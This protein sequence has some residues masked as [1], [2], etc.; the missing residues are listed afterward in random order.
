[1][2]IFSLSKQQA[3]WLNLA[4]LLV[5]NVEVF[6]ILNSIMAFAATITFVLFFAA[7]GVF[8]LAAARMQFEDAVTHFSVAFVLGAGAYIITFVALL[9]FGA[10]S[11]AF[12]LFSLALFALGIVFFLRKQK[13]VR[14]KQNAF[15]NGGLAWVFLYCIAAVFLISDFMIVTQSGVF[16]RD[17]LHAT[18][19]GGMSNF[20]ENTIFTMPDLAYEGKNLAYHFG[21]PILMNFLNETL[22]VPLLTVGYQIIPILCL[23]FFTLLLYAFAK[24]L[25]K[26]EKIRLFTILVLLFANLLVIPALKTMTPMLNWVAFMGSYGVGLIL[27]MCLLLLLEKRENHLV[28]EAIILS[29]LAFSKSTLF[30]PIFATYLLTNGL[31][32]WKTR[33]RV[34]LW[35][36]LITI[37]GLFY[38]VFLILAGTHQHNLWML[39]PGFMGVSIAHFTG[40]FYYLLPL[41]SLVLAVFGIFGIVAFF[42]MRGVWTHSK[43]LWQ[44]KKFDDW[45]LFVWTAIAISALMTIFLIEF[46]EGNSVQFVF[47][48]IILGGMLFFN[49]FFK[50]RTNRKFFTFTLALFFVVSVIP[51]AAIYEGRF[52]VLKA[53]PDSQANIITGIKFESNKIA[54][55]ALGA[56]GVLDVIKAVRGKYFGACQESKPYYGWYFYSNDLLQSLYWLRENTQKNEVVLFGRHY[57]AN[58]NR[59]VSEW[60]PD[61]FMRSAISQRQT[62]VEN[63]QFRGEVMQADYVERTKEVVRFYRTAVDSATYSA[64]WKLMEGITPKEFSNSYAWYFA[65]YKKEFFDTRFA[66]FTQEMS[67]FFKT[68]ARWSEEEKTPKAQSFLCKHT[69]RYVVL[70]DGERFNDWFSNAFNPQKVFEKGGVS[71][72][73]VVPCG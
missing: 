43:S 61:G 33:E 65:L 31:K 17:A 52:G 73:G 6:L 30:V 59:C 39:Y 69:V 36:F 23:V 51:N 44:G 19:E 66:N 12:P 47:P 10:S 5:L 11:L 63:L 70:E 55:D 25:I 22:G 60:W 3:F 57:E 26:D 21:S 32:W 15:E 42:L 40:V 38:V 68:G 48:A 2:D 8:T 4:L 64:K 20:E 29:A 67:A 58:E 41:L 71:V 50:D 7:F 72:W 54:M 24:R 13:L 56:V 53:A 49:D 1:M 37:P 62:L 35:K 16:V 45:T 14:F 28:L 46:V 18:Y 34:Y 9:V 27:L